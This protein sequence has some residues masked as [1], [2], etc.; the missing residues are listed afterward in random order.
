M[1]IELKSFAS[2]RYLALLTVGL[3]PLLGQV[4]PEPSVQ[5]SS[6]TQPDQP[7][8][9][10]Q[11][12]KLDVYTVTG[13][14]GSLA[15]AEEIKQNNSH[16][17][18]S[19][20]ASDIDKLPD[21]NVS[22]ALARIPGVQ[23]AHTFSGLGGNGAVTIQ[24]LNQIVNTLDGHEVSTPGGIANG[25]AGVGVGQRTFD[26]SQIPSSLVAGIDVYKTPSADQ[27]D[28]G[29]GGL[30]DVRMHRPFDFADGITG[31]A[32][33]GTTYSVLK[34]G[35][36]QNYNLMASAAEKTAIG[37]IGVLVSYSNIVTPWREDAITVGNPVADGTV[38]P[39]SPNALI[40][41]S[42]LNSSSYGEFKTQGG[43][44]VLQWQ[45]FDSFEIHLNFNPNKW[46]NIQD[47][48]QFSAAFSAATAVAG[49]GT[50][51]A[52]SSTA[53][54]SA[55]FSNVT[56]TAYGLTRDLQNEL[57][58]LS[59]GG[60]ITEGS[61]TVKFDADGYTSFNRF[62]NNLVF[63]SVAMPTVS[64]NLAGKIPSVT[65]AGVNLEDPS[66]YRLSQVDY[67]LYPSNTSSDAGRLDAE[68]NF[69]NFIIDKLAAGFRYATTTNSNLPTGLFLG[70][71]NIPA[72]SNLL[73]QH[74]GLWVQN[75]IQ[76]FF[77]PYSQTQFVQYLVQN[78]AQMRDASALYADYGANVLPSQSATVNPLSLFSIKEQT[79]AGY[80]MP[81]FQG[82]V[83]NLPF[84]GNAG[85]RM[86][87]TQEDAAGYQGT[88]AA[89]A[90]PFSL[91]SAYNDWLPSF[92]FRL[93]ILD[94]LFFRAAASKTITRPSFS[95]LSPS[96]TLNANPVNP[97]LNSGSQGN[98]SLQPVRANSYDLALEWYPQKSSVFYVTG[99]RKDVKGFIGSFSLP[100]TYSG[101][102]YL[103]Q[104]YSNLNPAT[105]N[106]A[107]V[108]FQHFFTNLPAPFNGLGFQ[109]NY[110]LAD[111]STPTTV[112]GDGTP[113]NAPLQ[114]LSKNTYNL[115]GMYESGPF[116]ARLGWNYR[117]DFVTGFAYYVNTGLLAQ[118]LAGYGDL[119]ASINFQITKN[120]EIAIQGTNLTNTLRYQYYG[121]K[122][123]PSNVFTDGLQLMTSITVHF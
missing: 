60:K 79:T 106:G 71:Y 110:T 56:G 111:S 17:V 50:M 2:V 78:T 7:G 114:N 88:S 41:S 68:Y 57:N 118:E 8:K 69:G 15:D 40:P 44:I 39:G 70:A 33:F 95:Q 83:F 101:V 96:L 91:L 43:E 24:G 10:D 31:A 29:L 21:I 14:R 105:I 74:P 4:A 48:S 19:I 72:T 46:S 64:Y 18:D 55:T 49:S 86:V 87:R 92:N 94:T 117:S 121:S 54:E 37:R 113:V 103:I 65:Y 116:S 6:T 62:Y 89:N 26:Y 52:G 34:D 20:V 100:E 93:K 3:T 35:E 81:E 120:V 115:V 25:T 5:T 99:F 90:V 30:I 84:D 85:V 59:L 77:Q 82:T 47:T 112:S 109:A 27:L 38:T 9:S 97:N 123:F 104:T 75:P 45:P 107:E 61:L 11:I 1:P 119:D 58:I 53:T 13:L 67:R 98:P 76:D 51:F 66:Q 63:A 122:E 12:V 108:G 102:T 73:S 16:I 80:L 32:T 22:Y 42:Y 36:N 28:G 23:L